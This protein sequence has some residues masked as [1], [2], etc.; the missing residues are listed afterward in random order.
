MKYNQIERT[1][2]HLSNQ[3]LILIS[4]TKTFHE[5]EKIFKTFYEAILA[6]QEFYI[7]SLLKDPKS[8]RLLGE[9]K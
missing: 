4:K 2:Y 8:K 7:E 9:I 3:C 1:I 6:I 5:K